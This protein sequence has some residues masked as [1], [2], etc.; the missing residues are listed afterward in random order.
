MATHVVRRRRPDGLLRIRNTV[1]H[2]PPYSRLLSWGVVWG[3]AGALGVDAAPTQETTVSITSWSNVRGLVASRGEVVY[4]V[5]SLKAG[6]QGVA[7]ADI[8][9]GPDGRVRSVDVVESPDSEIAS[10]T[11]SGLKAWKFKPVS[12]PGGGPA[13]VR[14][15]IILYFRIANGRGEVLTPDEMV[16]LHTGAATGAAALNPG[17][18]PSSFATIDEEMYKR[19]VTQGTAKPILVDIRDRAGFGRGAYPGAINLPEREI[20]SRAAAELPRNRQIV[21]DCPTAVGDLCSFA[22]ASLWRQGFIQVVLL[23]RK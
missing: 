12:A 22:A 4:P 18:P 21:L 15:K 5:A 17:P 23:Q 9:I 13:V 7:V 2:V 10:A 20:S 1:T 19:L 6:R 16:A 14:S 11:A 3:L 8:L